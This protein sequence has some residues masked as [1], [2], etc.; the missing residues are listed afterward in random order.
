LLHDK[1]N[2]I[3]PQ[4]EPEVKPEQRKKEKDRVGAATSKQIQQNN[5]VQV[6]FSR[7]YTI[8][9][10]SDSFYGLIDLFSDFFFDQ[11]AFQFLS[12]TKSSFQ[13]SSTL[14]WIRIS[15]STA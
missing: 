4:P 7:Q 8:Y 12:V 15:R 14:L 13:E 1:Q 11:F 5:G 10:T 9:G 6:G 3:K 2:G